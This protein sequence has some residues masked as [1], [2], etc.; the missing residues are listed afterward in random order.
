MIQYMQVHDSIQNNATKQLLLT[1][2]TMSAPN[3]GLQVVT[4]YLRAI[5]IVQCYTFYK[6]IIGPFESQTTIGR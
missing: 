2:V 6:L 3:C 5:S 1:R 4:K